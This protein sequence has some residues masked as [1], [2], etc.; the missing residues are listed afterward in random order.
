[1]KSRV[2]VFRE[3]CDDDWEYEDGVGLFGTYLTMYCERKVVVMDE[4]NENEIE[5]YIR[6]CIKATCI[7]ESLRCTLSRA[8]FSYTFSCNWPIYL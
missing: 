2:A 8:M 4:I 6:S 7:T 1:M 3:E 5:V